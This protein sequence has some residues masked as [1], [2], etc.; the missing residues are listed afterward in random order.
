VVTLLINAGFGS[1]WDILF[2]KYTVVSD[3][4]IILFYFIN[5]L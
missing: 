4:V 3:R 2:N 1:K 5:L